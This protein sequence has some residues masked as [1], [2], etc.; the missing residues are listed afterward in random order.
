MHLLAIL[1]SLR[2]LLI[3]HPAALYK[4]PS[5]RGLPFTRWIIYISP[6]SIVAELMIWFF[7]SMSMRYRRVFYYCVFIVTFLSFFAF[8]RSIWP[9][10]SNVMKP[11]LLEEGF[12]RSFST[13]LLIFERRMS[14]SSLCLSSWFRSKSQIHITF[15][16]YAGLPLDTVFYSS[17]KQ[18]P[19]SGI[20]SSFYFLHPVFPA[21]IRKIS[22]GPSALASALPSIAGLFTCHLQA[23]IMVLEI[24]GWN[25]LDALSRSIS[26][27][28]PS[29][30]YQTLLLPCKVL[31]PI[32]SPIKLRYARHSMFISN[33]GTTIQVSFTKNCSRLYFLIERSHTHSRSQVVATGSLF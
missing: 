9:G 23:C 32:F 22:Q 24:F 18:G 20:F 12:T 19:R 33:E 3:N 26:S 16:H 15:L 25:H 13:R 17:A 31:D 28:G 11:T 1:T 14:W 2:S 7:G 21:A 10:A 30:C 8:G 4:P 29:L 6:S 5:A 27:L